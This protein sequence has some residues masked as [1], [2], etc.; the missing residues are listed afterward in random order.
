M[1][2]RFVAPLVAVFALVLSMLPA[3]AVEACKGSEDVRAR[4]VVVVVD[5]GEGSG[6]FLNTSHILTA[7]H[8]VKDQDVVIVEVGGLLQRRARV[9][10]RDVTVDLALLE[11]ESPIAGF[12]PLTVASKMPE[13]GAA[14]QMWSWQ[15]GGV[16]RLGVVEENRNVSVRLAFVGQEAAAGILMKT[17]SQYRIT[18]AGVFG[19]SGSGIYDC[20]GQLV[21]VLTGI[22]NKGLDPQKWRE[23]VTT[24]EAV[25]KNWDAL[26]NSITRPESIQAFLLLCT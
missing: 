6:V 5:E 7:N 4:A 15:Q 2:S 16:F 14:Y 21:G 23:E 12:S 11:L 10:A 22:L 8:V 17:G 24:V 20:Q 9:K 13:A 3:G 19:D 1:Q 18:T 25:Q 26:S